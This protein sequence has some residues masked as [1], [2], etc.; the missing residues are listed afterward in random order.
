MAEN[1]ALTVCPQCDSSLSAPL[2]SGRVV[3]RECGWTD[4]PKEVET[5]VSSFEPES[6]AETM[7]NRPPPPLMKA[8]NGWMEF[9]GIMLFFIGALMTCGGFFMDTTVESDHS[10]DRIHNTGLL[11][12]RLATIQTGGISAICGAIFIAGGG[13]KGRRDE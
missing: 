3:C 2:K 11:N 7:A 4:K 9:F 6:F 12:D 10:Y 8:G 5:A 1:Q 13:S